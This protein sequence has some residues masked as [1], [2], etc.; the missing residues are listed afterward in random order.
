MLDRARQ[1]TSRSPVRDASRVTSEE[2]TSDQRQEQ[3]DVEQLSTALPVAA[4]PSASTGALLP[5]PEALHNEEWNSK[6]KARVQQLEQSIPEPKVSDGVTSGKSSILEQARQLASGYRTSK[7]RRGQRE[8]GSEKL[9]PDAVE[10][11]EAEWEELQAKRGQ[12][13]DLQVW[14]SSE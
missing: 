1:M 5:E 6:L 13:G 10:P 3:P 7:L 2:Q 14:N 11:A 4:S 9:N 8:L 12:T